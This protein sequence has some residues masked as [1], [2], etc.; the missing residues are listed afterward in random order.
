MTM[1]L[2]TIHDVKRM[3]HEAM[4]RFVQ[5]HPY[6]AFYCLLIGMPLLILALLFAV[7]S[8]AAL[9]LSLLFGWL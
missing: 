5:A 6:L 8:A 9:V 2:H 1:A 4:I 7:T 3:A